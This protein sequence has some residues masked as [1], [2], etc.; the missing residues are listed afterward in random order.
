[1]D[2]SPRA[3]ITQRQSL[4]THWL[5]VAEARS[6]SRLVQNLKKWN[7][8][9]SEWTALRKIYQQRYVSPIEFVNAIGITKGGASKLVARLVE[10]GLARKSVSEYDRRF[11]TVSLTEQ[12]ET[13][14]QIMALAEDLLDDEFVVGL[15]RSTRR[16]LR[17]VLKKLVL[18]PLR[19]WSH[20]PVVPAIPQLSTFRIGHTIDDRPARAALAAFAARE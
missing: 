1:M 17:G 3:P 6:S 12:G 11:R 15:K 13:L 16:R 20:W 18:A 4:V 5:R 9:P 19:Y 10:K 8:I 14:V 7:L 2:R